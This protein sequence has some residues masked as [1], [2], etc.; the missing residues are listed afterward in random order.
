MA[1][2]SVSLPGAWQCVC[3]C[4]RVHVCVRGKRAIFYTEVIYGMSLSCVP[5]LSFPK[6]CD[7]SGKTRTQWANGRDKD[8]L[9]EL[10]VVFKFPYLWVGLRHGVKKEEKKTQKKILLFSW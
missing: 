7:N 5:I 1:Q 2:F 3:V 6:H 10:F 9:S 8:L 4:A